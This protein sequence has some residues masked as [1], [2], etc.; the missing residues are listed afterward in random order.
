MGYLTPDTNPTDT[1]CRVLLIPNNQE[2]IANVLGAIQALTFAGNWDKQG[3]LTPQE[4]ADAMLPMF[5]SLCFNE[6]VCRV[7]GEIIAYA[8]DTSP[9]PTKWL[10]CD[11]SSLLRADYP[12]LFLIIGTAY[13]SA[14]STHFN[15]PDL[16]GRS[17]GGAGSG[18]GLTTRA[19]GDQYG[20]ELHVLVTAE[21]A[22]HTHADVGHTHVEGNAAPALGAA[23]V[24]VPV[25][26][27]VP[28]VGVTG[29]GSANLTSTGSDTGHNTIGP[30]LTINY[31]IVALQ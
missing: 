15:L 26:S 19:V 30:R 20:E 9:D 31:L 28:A 22:S 4:A 8:G 13:G 7:I 14:D 23:I 12:D 6:G 29:S 1:V 21:L 5:D 18:S 27:A 17:A 16:Q 24:G 11:G 10:V 2:F 3:A 25:P